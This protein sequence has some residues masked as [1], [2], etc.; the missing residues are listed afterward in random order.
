MSPVFREPEASSRPPRPR[1]GPALLTALLLLAI[2]CG[3]DLPAA[4]P[5]VR[6][7]AVAGSFYPDDAGMLRRAIRFYL[8]DAEGGSV[9]G[10]RVIVAPHAG[11]VYSG[12][13]AAD[14]WAR[15]ARE[16]A[17]VVF[18]LGTNHTVAPFREVSVWHA[19]AYRTPL[20][21][22]LVDEGIARELMNSDPR[23]VFR[24]DA[25]ER[26]HSVEVQVPFVQVLF[27]GAK[28]V[29]LVVGAPDPELCE[30][31]GRAIA[32]LAGGRRAVIAASSDLSHYPEWEDAVR[33]DGA[34]LRAVAEGDRAT[35][36]RVMEEELRRGA[37]GLS[38]CACGEGPV[39]AALAAAE[40]L[41]LPSAEVVS[42]AN[43]GDTALGDRKRV[44]GYGAVAFGATGGKDPLA[45][46]RRPEPE[47][48][49]RDF[50]E[51]ERRWLLA[52]ARRAVVQYLTSGTAPLARPEGAGLWRRQGAFVTL[53]IGDRLRG[54]IGHMAENRPL[55]QV[56]GAMALQ[57][58]FNDRRFSPLTAKELGEIRVEISVLTPKRRVSGPE[59]IVI[60]RDGVVLEKDGRSAVYLPQVA[61]EEGW[62][63]EEMLGHL[64]RKAGLPADA[65]RRGAALWTFRA[66]VFG[67]GE[68]H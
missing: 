45:G 54:C 1:R 46:L 42:Y 25:H 41:G 65:W 19:G 36:V 7:P 33:V 17:D 40:A 68:V 11:Y 12:Q 8:D 24:P 14:A 20:G 53:E 37:P 47:L 38:T 5:G 9:E 66:E 18:I 64:A 26:E 16:E 2:G 21:D 43:S 62:N 49:E 13:I 57:A 55:C 15:A 27:P 35:V 10:V 44:V 48:S 30:A 61:P 58:A 39:L 4:G 23:F 22:A 67:E 63:R 3:S 32:R 51:E 34:V 28:I 6:P 50:D 29:P 52:H 56:V 31:L 60:G 59:D